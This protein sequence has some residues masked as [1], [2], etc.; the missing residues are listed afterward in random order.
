MGTL[1]HAVLCTLLGYDVLPGLPHRR[2]IDGMGYLVRSLICS[3]C[4]R[5]IL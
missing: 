4:G 2:G 1:K 3:R 5:K